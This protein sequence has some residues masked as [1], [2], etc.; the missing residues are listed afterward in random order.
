MLQVIQ[1]EDDFFVVNMKPEG[2]KPEDVEMYV[3]QLAIKHDGLNKT[4]LIDLPKVRDYVIF[5]QSRFQG[6]HDVRN[7]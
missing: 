6:F 1:L 3:N 7:Q 5:L 4:V 2:W